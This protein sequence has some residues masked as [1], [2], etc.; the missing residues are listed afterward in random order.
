M[1]AESNERCTQDLGI[2]LR[3][4]MVCQNLDS[5]FNQS[6]LSSTT[7]LTFVIFPSQ[8]LFLNKNDLFEKKVPTSDI[9]RYFS[10]III[11]GMELSR[12]R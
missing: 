6:R 1:C 2:D 9:Q 7:G 5:T 12:S 8:I 10:V 4:E 3:I 11:R